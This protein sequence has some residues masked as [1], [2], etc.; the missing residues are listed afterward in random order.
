MAGRIFVTVLCLALAFVLLTSAARASECAEATVVAPAAAD[1][2]VDANS[3][4][5]NKGSDTLLEVS[6][7]SRALVRFTLPGAVPPGCVIE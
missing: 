5:V 1:S 6:G 2:W 7:T 4:L 3:P